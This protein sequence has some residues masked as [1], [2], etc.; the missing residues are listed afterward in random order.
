MCIVTKNLDNCIN[1]VE[2]NLFS[3][4]HVRQ[5]EIQSCLELLLN[6]RNTFKEM[7]NRFDG[8]NRHINNAI[9]SLSRAIKGKT[10]G[11]CNAENDIVFYKNCKDAIPEIEMAFY[12]VREFME[13]HQLAEERRLRQINRLRELTLRAV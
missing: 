8:A 3:P 13:L 9:G 5:T 2:K 10:C 6:T 1:I 12:K 11:V 7:L 4:T